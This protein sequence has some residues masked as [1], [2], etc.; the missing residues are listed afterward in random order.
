M[1]E[2]RRK[3]AAKYLTEAEI[4]ALF[5]V[6]KNPRDRAIFRVAYHRG[7]R[8]SEVGMLQLADYRAP[9]T[10]KGSYARLFV[11]RLKRSISQE[12]LLTLAE[13]TALRAWLRIRGSEPGPLFTSR[14][15]AGIGRRRLDE[16]MKKYAKLAGLPVELSHM[17]SLKHASGTHTLAILGNLEAVRDHLGHAS[18]ASTEIYAKFTR[19]EETGR[20]LRGWG[21]KGQ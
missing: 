15:H 16:L 3:S 4:E 8:A 10:V 6:I 2:D 17:H 9:L 13:Q 18:L 11:H 14:N 21:R 5:S 12:Y 19:H 7:L 20:A 1:R